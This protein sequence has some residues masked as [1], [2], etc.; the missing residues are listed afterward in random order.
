MP[1]AVVR[2]A[3]ERDVPSILHL[4][5]QAGLDEGTALPLSEAQVIFRKIR[6]RDHQHLYV[7]ETGGTV[8][9]TFVLLIVETLGHGGSRCGFVE[10]VAVDKHWRGRGIGRQMMDFARDLCLRAG[11]FKLTLSSH[12]ERE[13]AHRFYEA[14]GYRRHGYSFFLDIP[15][16]NPDKDR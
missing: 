6:A 14:L 9:G 5:G 8:V 4:Y 16:S 10:D 13:P 3:T 7:A 11:C 1:T 12:L 2:S 15:G